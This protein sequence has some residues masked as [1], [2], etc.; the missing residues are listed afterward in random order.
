[1]IMQPAIL[2]LLLGSILVSFMVVYAAGYGVSILR[3]W[4]LKDGSE[5]QLNLE[6]KTYLI[7]TVMSYTFGFQLLSLFLFIFCADKLSGLFVGAMC[8]AGTLN[9]N[10]FGYPALIFKIINFILGGVWLIVNYTDNRA[11]DYPLIKKKYAFLLVVAPFILCEMALQG[12]FFLNLD[13][14]IITSCCGSLFSP[15]GKGLGALFLSSL[16]TVPMK[17]VFYAAVILT[18]VSGFM[19][20]SRGRPVTGY[21]FSLMSIITFSVAVAALISFIS[22]YI[23]QLPTHHCPFCILQK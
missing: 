7:S 10:G 12:A 14:H 6:R 2:A 5:L 22:L 20:Y 15:E 1:M 21:F 23:Y 19:F 16:P 3:N 18:G 4:D 8:A 13:P 9:M 11:F 17:I